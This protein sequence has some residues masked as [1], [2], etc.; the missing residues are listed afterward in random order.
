MKALSAHRRS[1]RCPT[2]PALLASCKLE[3]D[4]DMY[5]IV[6]GISDYPNGVNDLDSTDDDARDMADLLTSQG[7][8]VVLRVTDESDNDAHYDQLVA[9][10]GWAA[11]G[12]GLE[13]DDLFLFYFSGHGFKD[14]EG[15][16]SSPGSDQDDEVL[17]MVDNASTEP[18]DLR[19]TVYLT[20]DELAEWLH[21]IPCARRIVILDSCYSGGFIANAGEADAI[22]PDYSDGSNGFLDTLGDT[23]RLYANFQDYGSDIAPGDALV[24][25]ASGER[26]Y[27]YESSLGNGMMTWYLLES[28]SRGD[29]NRDGYVTVSEAYNYIYRNINENFNANLPEGKD[30]FFPHVSGG[31]VDYVL[32][33]K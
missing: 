14:P 19:A 32:F 30:V 1:G 27:A 33:V 11:S 12:A 31:P 29:S 23:I 2:L 4:Y 16:E 22:P 5:A 26:D 15:V 6:Y 9:D 28:A 7:Y 8:Q 13:L 24:I 10:F 18:A 21:T 25:A 20:D 3:I 17:V